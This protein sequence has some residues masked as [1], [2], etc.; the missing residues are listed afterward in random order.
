MMVRTHEQT[1]NLMSMAEFEQT[2]RTHSMQLVYVILY[3]TDFD[4]DC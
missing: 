2:D 4:H 1:F 3:A